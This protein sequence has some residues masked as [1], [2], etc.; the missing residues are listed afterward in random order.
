MTQLRFFDLGIRHDPLE[1]LGDPLLTP[2]QT[3]DWGGFSL[4]SRRS[5][6]KERKSNV[7][8]K[9]YDVMLMSKMSVLQH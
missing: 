9:P 7:G 4:S 6:S 5:S 8:R 2:Q 3:V 1:A